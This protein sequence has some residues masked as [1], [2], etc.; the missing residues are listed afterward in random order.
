M[1]KRLE[2]TRLKMTEPRETEQRIYV[3]KN[4][5]HRHD[6]CFFV[7]REMGSYVPRK[8]NRALFLA[9]GLRGSVSAPQKDALFHV[10]KPL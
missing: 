6:Y 5:M 1:G 8:P 7:K 2:N 10:L 3:C 9:H 4:E